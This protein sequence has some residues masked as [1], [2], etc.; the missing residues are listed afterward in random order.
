M[1]EVVER[2]A[3]AAY[4]ICAL[5]LFDRVKRGTGLGYTQDDTTGVRDLRMTSANSRVMADTEAAA[6]GMK[7]M[8]RG[9][10]GYCRG[11]TVFFRGATPSRGFAAALCWHGGG[12]AGTKDERVNGPLQMHFG[13]SDASILI[14]DVDAIRAVRPKAEVYVYKRAGHCFGCD[15]S[16]NFIK[17]DCGLAQH[18][19]IHK[20]FR[21]R[22]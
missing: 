12:I 9:I 1:R 2:F 5:V 20:A 21:L 18:R 19:T 16:M 7:G 4:A 3:A 17:K 15:Q 22:R 6:D 10:A 8:K 11:G 14:R 13:E